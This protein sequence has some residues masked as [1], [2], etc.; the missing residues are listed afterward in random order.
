[1]VRT[2]SDSSSLD[3]NEVEFDE[4]DTNFRFWGIQAST[5][6]T[7]WEGSAEIYLLGLDENDTDERATRNRKIYT[8]GF[9][10]YRPRK[11]CQFDYQVESMIQWGN[12]DID[13]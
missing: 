8:G 7:A 13:E 12:P 2:P 1:M 11:A 9:R 3:Q 10:L 4:E 6:N 5:D